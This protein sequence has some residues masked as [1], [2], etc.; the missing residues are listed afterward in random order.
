MDKI[1]LLEDANQKPE[2]HITKNEYW[3]QNNIG[4]YRTRLPVG[5]YVLVNDRIKDVFKRKM[6]RKIPVKMLDLLG[7]YNLVVDTKKDIQELITDVQGE[8]E[9]FRDSMILCRNNNIRLIVLVENEGCL[10]KDKNGA[11]ENPTVLTLEDLKRWRNPRSYIYKYGR[12]LHPRA[13]K[14][15]QLYKIC[16]TMSERYGVE[17]QFCTPEEAGKKVLEILKEGNN[18]G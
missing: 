17:F 2:K 12:Q 7:C 8:H 5:D 14:G 11:Y 18:D 13:M 10:L 4:V 6:M 16:K 15:D 9:R 1:W 3:K